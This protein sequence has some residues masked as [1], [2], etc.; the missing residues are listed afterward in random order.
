MNVSPR[1]LAALLALVVGV[2]VVIFQLETTTASLALSV[3]SV[4][5]IVGSLFLLFSPPETT[6]A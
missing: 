1:I 4:A 6:H 5:V 2:P 3:V